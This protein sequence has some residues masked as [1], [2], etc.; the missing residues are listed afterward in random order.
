MNNKNNNILKVIIIILAVILVSEILY[1]GIKFYHNRKISTFYTVV[2]SVV[3]D[4]DNTFVGAGFSDYRHSKFNKF[5]KGYDKATLFEIK[6]GK[7]VKEMGLKLG[8]NSRFNDLIEVKDGY[9]AVGKIEMSEDQQKE[10]I[11]EGLIAKFD[12]N[13][14]LVWRKNVSILEKTELYKVKLDGNDLVIVGTSVYSDGY[15]GNH[16]TGGGILLKYSLDGKQQLKVNNGGP[17]SGSFNDVLIEKDHY[18]VVGLGRKNSGIII[19]YDKNGNRIKTGSFGY[20]DKNGINAVAKKGNNYITATTKVVDTKNLSNYS[21][22]IVEFNS[23]LEKIDDIKYTNDKITYFNDIKVDKDGNVF[24]CGYTGHGKE[25]EVLTDGIVVKYDKDLYEKSY[26]VLKGK[27]ND[28]YSRIYLKDN[29]IY[30]L[31]YSNSKLKEFKTNG[32]DYYPVLKKYN[33]NLK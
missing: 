26:D 19:K 32:Y 24:V 16:T 22:A 3:L 5:D 25:K 18:I 8:L 13:F 17:Y 29:S 9:V 27:K 10:G 4:N 6:N 15:V 14:K 30:L 12:K 7:T 20:T 31:G 33:N 21:A 23:N 28:F 1:F 11:T 2:S